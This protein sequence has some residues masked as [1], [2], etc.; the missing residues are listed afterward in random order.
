M[1]SDVREIQLVMSENECGN[2]W[3]KSFYPRTNSCED[4]EQG[5]D[6][7]QQMEA[8][9]VEENDAEFKDQS[10]EQIQQNFGT[11]SADQLNSQSDN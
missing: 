1:K 7:G 3:A 11:E 5:T 6:D 8:I 4:E 2:D 9:L 10:Q